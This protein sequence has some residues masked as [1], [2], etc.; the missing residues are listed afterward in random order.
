ME[1][2]TNELFELL[3]K[4]NTHDKKYFATDGSHVCSDKK[5]KHR[6]SLQVMR[7]LLRKEIEEVAAE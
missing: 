1:R 6:H 3:T 2:M 7:R 5:F 4:T